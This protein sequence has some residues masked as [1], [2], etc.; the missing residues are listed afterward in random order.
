[1]TGVSFRL[2]KF[3]TRRLTLSEGMALFSAT[4][5]VLGYV[6]S[7]ALVSTGNTAVGNLAHNLLLNALQSRNNTT[8][9]AF[10]ASSF[11]R[12]LPFLAAMLV[13]GTSI[14][15]SAI[16][17]AINVLYGFLN[18]AL[19][20]AAYSE[21]S[22]G[23]IGFSALVLVPALVF[24][25][26]V[27]VLAGRESVCFSRRVLSNALPHGTAFNISA[28]FK[29][30]LQRYLFLIVFS[31]AASLVDSAAYALFFGYFDLGK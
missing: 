24:K 10:L 9:F 1:M 28:D 31:V 18:G 3:R 29:T 26:Y 23:G 15:G 16:I 11:F 30:Y 22:I 13:F 17:P 6:I 2:G 27:L 21:Y 20:S 4:A 7:A 8:F 14:V 5:F 12:F 25:A 19:I